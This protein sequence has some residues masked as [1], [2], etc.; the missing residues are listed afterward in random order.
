M[1]PIS[2]TYKLDGISAKIMGGVLVLLADLFR[3]T[4]LTFYLMLIDIVIP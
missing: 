1:Q 3:R 4:K 2:F